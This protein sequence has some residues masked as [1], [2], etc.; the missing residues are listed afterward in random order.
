VA[1]RIAPGTRLIET[2]FAR[3]LAVSRTPVREAIR[4]LAQ[5]GLAE[6]T[7]VGAKTQVTVT[8]ATVADLIELFAIIGALEGLAGRAAAELSAADRRALAGELDALNVRFAR[9]AKDRLRVPD[10][11][12]ETHDAFHARLV[13]RCASGPLRQQIDAVRPQIERYELLYARAAGPDFGPSLREHRAIVT[14][15]RSGSA[16][17]IERAVRVNWSNSAARLSAGVVAAAG[18]GALGA[19]RRGNLD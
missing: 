1:G 15:V 3:R 14:A 5:E 16:N 18:L 2:E 7:S 17:R 12:F 13:A 19:Y 4:R 6:A 8:P 10:R 9:A 11:F